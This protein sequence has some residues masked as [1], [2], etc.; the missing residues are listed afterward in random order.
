MRRLPARETAGRENSCLLD[1]AGEH[2]PKTKPSYVINSAKG[3]EDSVVLLTE[4]KRGGSKQKTGR[5][6]FFV[7]KKTQKPT[8]SSPPQKRGPQARSNSNRFALCSPSQQGRSL[9]QPEPRNPQK[10]Q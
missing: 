5:F 7:G 9:A 2:K 1:L 10:H 4:L 6:L 3:G 8:V